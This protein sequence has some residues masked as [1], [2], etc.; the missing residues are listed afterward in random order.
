MGQALDRTS[1]QRQRRAPGRSA[2]QD[3]S[4]LRL[5]SPAMT[6]RSFGEAEI[7]QVADWIDRVVRSSLDAKVIAE[8]AAEVRE[9]CSAHPLP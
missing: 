9:T 2:A 3:S 1:E 5:G 4:G 8:T 6:T 7:R